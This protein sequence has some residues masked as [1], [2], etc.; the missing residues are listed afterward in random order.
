MRRPH[1]SGAQDK[2]CIGLERIRSMAE[3]SAD[4]ERATAEDQVRLDLV[5]AL[6]P[7]PYKKDHHR[8]DDFVVE[9]PCAKGPLRWL[10]RY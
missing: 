2:S 7:L 9:E 8:C 5:D 10:R 4:L 3:S 6:V 1:D